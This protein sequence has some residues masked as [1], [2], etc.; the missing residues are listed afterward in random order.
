MGIP[1][2]ETEQ[3]DKPG[4]HEG[5]EEQEDNLQGHQQNQE[6]GD[7]ENCQDHTAELRQDEGLLLVQHIKDA[8][9]EKGSTKV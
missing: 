9:Q 4:D 8:N 3:D 6:D 2:K 7:L 5:Q 1:E